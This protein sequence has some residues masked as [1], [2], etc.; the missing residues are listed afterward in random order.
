MVRPKCPNEPTQRARTIS[1]RPLVVED[2]TM[3]VVDFVSLVI[4]ALIDGPFEY[5]YIHGP[6]VGSY[7][8]W[9]NMPAADVCAEMTGVGA[10]HWREH[11]AVC[12][13]TI[14]D[15]ARSW[16]LLLYCALYCTLFW[17]IWQNVIKCGCHR[18]RRT[19]RRSGHESRAAAS[20][21]LTSASLRVAS[22]GPASAVHV[23]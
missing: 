4:W 23:K 3:N 15:R 17:A 7:G 13:E 8:F 19:R 1:G 22:N 14:R 11:I 16:T 21:A 12:T 9:Q 6:R 10:A 20:N 2:A 5:L 18:R